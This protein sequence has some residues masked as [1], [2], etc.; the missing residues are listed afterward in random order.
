M[1]ARQLVTVTSQ[2]QDPG[3]SAVIS[4]AAKYC[5]LNVGIPEMDEGTDGEESTDLYS[6]IQLD[7]Y[8]TWSY[9]IRN[10]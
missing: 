3:W 2:L 6:Q 9:W 1:K 10:F 7:W 8:V 4:S 5:P